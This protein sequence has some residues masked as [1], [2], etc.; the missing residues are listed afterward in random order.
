MQTKLAHLI[1]AL[2]C[3]ALSI[4][5]SHLSTAYAQGTTAFTYQGRL[6]TGT[7][8][9][10]GSYDMTFAV[11]DAAVS[12]NL[13]AGPITNSAVAVSNGLF[14]VT[15]NFGAGVFTGTNY[16][17]Q[18]AVSPAGLGTFTTLVPNQQLTPAPYALS[19]IS[20]QSYA[21]C[22][23][24]SIMAFGGN[25]IPAGWLLCN[26]TNVSRTTYANLF[27]AIGTAWGTG[28]GSTTFNLP[29]TRGYF[30][31]GVDGGVG[32]DPDTA[33]RTVNPNP[34]FTGGNTGNIGDSV[35][36]YQ[37]DMFKN[38]THTLENAPSVSF[39]TGSGGEGFTAG[40]QYNG[41]NPTPSVGTSP[42]GGDET[43]SKN[44]YVNYI[45]K[46]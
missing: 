24:G 20:P 12:G 6:N 36:S 25:N 41:P 26:G 40:N 17:V 43:R 22:P 3:L 29:D 11:Y 18:M 34:S 27:A 4:L 37:Q 32:N 33:S 21:L 2:A 35:G 5:N 44:V 38:H 46:Y 42:E 15:L 31:R 10:N 7:N 1:A 16:W 30:L 9:A 23:P 45:I 39:Y 19:L 8:A 28:D 13:I 14:T